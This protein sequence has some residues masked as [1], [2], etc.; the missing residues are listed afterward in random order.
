MNFEERVMKQIGALSLELLK[1]QHIN[2]E[3][4]AKIAELEKKEVKT[5]G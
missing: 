3:L 2:E 4:S 1:A 5:D